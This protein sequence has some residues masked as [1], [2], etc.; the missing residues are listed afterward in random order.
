MAQLDRGDY[1]IGFLK[2]RNKTTSDPSPS[3]HRPDS[4]SGPGPIGPEFHRARAMAMG[5]G[6]A[7]K[8]GK[9]RMGLKRRRIIR[10]RL[11]TKCQ[12]RWLLIITYVLLFE[13]GR[14]QSF[15]GENTFNHIM[16]WLL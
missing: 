7:L 15:Q 8:F 13:L 4:Q 12:G 14:L 2:N 10:T 9:R 16:T 6:V 1:F 3:M 5:G 11:K